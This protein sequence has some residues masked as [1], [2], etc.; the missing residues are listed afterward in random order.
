[1]VMTGTHDSVG[2]TDVTDRVS[3]DSSSSSDRPWSRGQRSYQDS[4]RRHPRAHQKP[5]HGD[6]TGHYPS[7][8]GIKYHLNLPW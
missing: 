7:N 4:D 5:R 6:H 8:R 1:M 2:F 3:D